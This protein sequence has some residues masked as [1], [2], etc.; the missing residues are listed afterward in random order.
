M[1]APMQTVYMQD[2]RYKSLPKSQIGEQQS[3]IGGIF[4]SL[5]KK[6]HWLERNRVLIFSQDF[7]AC[8]K[9]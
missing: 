5:A 8:Q 1:L 6:Q 4:S 9:I 2:W 3:R 7:W